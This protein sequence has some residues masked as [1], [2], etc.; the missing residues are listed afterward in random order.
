MTFDN[1]N[2]ATGEFSGLMMESYLIERGELGDTIRQAT[3]GIGLVDMFSRIDMVG[4]E[5]RSAFGVDTPAIRIS[6]AKVG[7]SA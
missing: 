5:S 2:L 3:V 1:P 6:S 4:K 7:G